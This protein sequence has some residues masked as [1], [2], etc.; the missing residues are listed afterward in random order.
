MNPQARKIIDSCESNFDANKDNCSGF[1]KA[2]SADFNITM[3]GQADDLVDFLTSSSDWTAIVDGT[4]AAAK[5]KADQSFLVMGGLKSSELTPP[6]A[7]GHVVIVVSGPLDSINNKYPLGY[8]GVLN[9]VGE[10]DASISHAFNTTD[11]DDVHY[12]SRPLP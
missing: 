2:V 12:F 3:T 10:K 4:G 11:R 7:N 8:W 1:I 6:R 9:G 5:E